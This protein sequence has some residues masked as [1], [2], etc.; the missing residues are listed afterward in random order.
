VVRWVL[1]IAWTMHGLGHF[2][3]V[4]G[5]F[6]PPKVSGFKAENPWLLPGD[7]LVTGP[8]GRIWSLVWVAAAVLIVLSVYGL[9][10]AAEWWRIAA[11]WGAVASL[12][13]ILPWMRTVPPGAIV[14]ALVSTGVIVVLSV[15]VDSLLSLVEI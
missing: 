2:A 14:G 9:F 12:V 10:A 5:A 7:A 13:A 1:V 4:L 3:G 6:A 15:P 8:V 11:L